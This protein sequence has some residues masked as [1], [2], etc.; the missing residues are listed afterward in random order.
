M[1]HGAKSMSVITL[2]L[3]GDVGKPSVEPK[4]YRN[5]NT[6]VNF[7]TK[8]KYSIVK[9]SLIVKCRIN[10]LNK[11]NCEFLNLYHY[12]DTHFVYNG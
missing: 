11:Q 5:E 7:G 2:T 12:F 3:N 8:Q 10:N 6:H 1:L 4:S 9:Q